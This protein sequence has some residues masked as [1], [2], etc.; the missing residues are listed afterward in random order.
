MFSKSIGFLFGAIACVSAYD[1]ACIYPEEADAD[2]IQARNDIVFGFLPPD[3]ETPMV[4]HGSHQLTMCQA[5]CLAY[6][7]PDMKDPLTSEDTFFTVPE[8]GQNGYA[9]IMCLAQCKMHTRSGNREVLIQL[10]DFG[11]NVELAG[12]DRAL[13]I[14]AA[15]ETCDLGTTCGGGCADI[16]RIVRNSGYDPYV[17]GHFVGIVIDDFFKHDGWNRDGDEVYDYATDSP[18]PCTSSCR[19]Y[20][21]TVGYSPVPDPRKFA[22]YRNSTSKY[23]C[24]GNCRR[25]QPLQEGNDAGN[26]IRQESTATHIGKHAHT[27]LREPTL[28]LEDPM[29]DLYEDSLQVIEEVKITSGDDYRK[30]AV[31]LM[32]NKIKVRAMIQNGVIDQFVESREMSFEEY[33]IFLISISTVEHDGVVQAW[34]EKMQHDLVRPTTVIKHWNDDLLYT[35]GGDRDVDGPVEIRARD[36]EA[37]IRVMPHAEFPSGSSC[38]CTGYQEFTDT[39]LERHYGRSV[40]GNLTHRSQPSLNFQNMTEIREICGQSRIWGG[41]HYPEAVPAGEEICGGLGGL[42]ADWADDL[43][44]GSPFPNAFYRGDPRPVCGERR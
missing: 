38:L 6:H 11:F 41:M 3:E 29:Y 10:R 20:Q 14:R 2:L 25:W 37:F 17:V 5:A 32:D 35:F 36:F 19:K 7:T 33:I 1:I 4:I 16:C 44:N 18:V 40:D 26:L 21:D 39:W 13:E 28:T 9:A 23:E 34:H 15:V 42:G 43:R 22:S 30:A 31:K 8:F 12:D 24:Q 27:Y